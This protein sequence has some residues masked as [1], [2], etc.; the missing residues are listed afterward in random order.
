MGSTPATSNTYRSVLKRLGANSAPIQSTSPILPAQGEPVPY[1][2]ISALA[3]ANDDPDIFN[4]LLAS[5]CNALRTSPWHYAIC[6]LHESDPLAAVFADYRRI[7]AAGLLYVVHYGENSDAFIALD[8]RVPY[9]DFG[10][11]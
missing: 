3:V 4:Y 11:I 5:V 8:D 10:V 9:V 1:L 6:G 2:Y 7:E